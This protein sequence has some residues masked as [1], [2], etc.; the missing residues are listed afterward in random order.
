MDVVLEMPVGIVRRIVTFAAS[1]AFLHMLP[2]RA[3]GIFAE[4]LEQKQVEGE[5][6]KVTGSDVFHHGCLAT[7]F[8]ARFWNS[9]R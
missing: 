6:R 2:G 4:V 9:P 1:G 8:V 3:R 7:N 5:L